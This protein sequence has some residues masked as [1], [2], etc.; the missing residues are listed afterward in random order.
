ME[1]ENINDKPILSKDDSKK[2]S[3]DDILT[4]DS[5]NPMNDLL[6]SEEPMNLKEEIIKLAK[7]IALLESDKLIQDKKIASLEA[8]IKKIS[9]RMKK[10]ELLVKRNNINMDLLSNR[11]YI[12]TIVLLFGAKL[13]DKIKKYIEKDSIGN[14]YCKIKYTSL[15]TEVLKKINQSLDKFGFKRQGITPSKEESEGKES[16]IKKI[17]F[18]ECCHFIVCVIDNMIHPLQGIDNQETFS[19]IYGQRSISTLR[20][21]IK[22]FF[23]DPTSVDELQEIFKISEDKDLTMQTYFSAKELAYLTNKKYYM[24]LNKKNVYYNSFFIEHLFSPNETSIKNISMNISAEEFLKDIDNTIS[25]SKLLSLP[26][27]NVE[28]FIE[29]LKWN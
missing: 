12:K 11:D 8:Q 18:I 24:N 1:N 28:E 29:N 17:I 16:V 2:E 27:Q 14:Y 22:L 5:N 21:S 26:F 19:K 6:N 23:K 13:D 25:D 15:V 4:R 20:D 9:E 7:R 3:D 10:L